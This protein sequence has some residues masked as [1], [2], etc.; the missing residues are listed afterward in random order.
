[1]NWSEIDGNWPEM[2]AMIRSYWP[3]LG[4]DDLDRIAGDRSRL[5]ESLRDRYGRGPEEAERVICLF[6]KECRRPGAV[7]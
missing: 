1:M 6:E 4:E 3:K 7:K 5:A 2:R